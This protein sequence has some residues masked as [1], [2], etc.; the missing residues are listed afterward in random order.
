MMS[1]PFASVAPMVAT[2]NATPDAPDAQLISGAIIGAG[3]I[4]ILIRV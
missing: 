1:A 4:S 3:V 2:A